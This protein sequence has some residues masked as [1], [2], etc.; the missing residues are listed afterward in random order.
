MTRRQ[1]PDRIGSIRRLAGAEAFGLAEVYHG[2]DERLHR[3]VLLWPVRHAATVDP[4]HRA[5]LLHT[6]T[7]VGQ[8]DDPRLCQIYE[9]ISQEPGDLGKAADAGGERVDWLVL[10]SPP[11]AGERALSALP[12]GRRLQLAQQVAEVLVE[13][14]GRGAVHGGLGLQ[15]I[16]LAASHREGAAEIKILA[17]G[18]RPDADP[19]GAMPTAADD[20]GDFGELLGELLG[21]WCETQPRARARGFPSDQG[22]EP[23]AYGRISRIPQRRAGGKDPLSARSEFY[24]RLLGRD[25]GRLEGL[26]RDLCSGDRESRPTA[27]DALR[28]LS[29]ERLRPRRLLRRLAV[30]CGVVLALA[31]GVAYTVGLR[32]ALHAAVDA[33][34]DAIRARAEAEELARFLVGLFAAGGGS[35]AATAPRPVTARDL[36]ERGSRRIERD[37]ADR[38]RLRARFLLTLG[39]VY[40][41]LGSYYRAHQ[42]LA[43]SLRLRRAESPPRPTAVAE[44]LAALGSVARYQGDYAQ[45]EEFL[46][47]ALELQTAELGEDDVAVAETLNALAIVARRRGDYQTAEQH[48]LRSLG[49]RERRLGAF[50]P[51]VAR[52]LNNLG[53]LYYYQGRPEESEAMQRRALRIKEATLEANHPSIAKSL[54]NLANLLADQGR[55]GEAESYYRRSQ[56][57]WQEV[58]GPLHPERANSLNNLG[59]LNMEWGRLEQ[60]ESYL[61]QAVEV[62]RQALGTDHADTALSLSNL[63]TL[64]EV[65]GRPNEAG[66][67]LRRALAIQERILDPDHPDIGLSLDRLA[68]LHLSRQETATAHRLLERSYAINREALGEEHPDT[69]YSLL[70]LGRCHL[71][72]GDASSALGHLEHAVTIYRSSGIRGRKLIAALRALASAQAATGAAPLAEATLARAAELEPG[73]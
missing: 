22:V 37:F 21:D 3:D 67:L 8:L 47:S 40:K 60:A 51:A 16:C 13:L 59:L 35:G 30:A 71:A 50:D 18:R 9:C 17:P 73:A 55:Y 33:R 52:S 32:S 63:G 62:R 12:R 46:A 66:E 5:G 36:L 45:A 70:L 7:V 48:Y 65:R 26:V 29:D 58:G 34:E 11:V 24:T 49:I 69:A 27:A 54:N 43:E 4:A 41:G 28:R 31:W 53:L 42:L 72:S 19:A 56:E 23:Q 1:V 68:S 14:H 10:E 61:R 2:R 6:A 25:R 44:S 15:S 20:M 39:E 64:M 57:I 38:P